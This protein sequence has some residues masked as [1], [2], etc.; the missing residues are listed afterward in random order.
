[1]SAPTFGNHALHSKVIK[2]MGKR[3]FFHLPSSSAAEKRENLTYYA[4]TGTT[5]A[6]GSVC[7]IKLPQT[8]NQYLN[9]NASRFCGRV[10]TV[11]N[12]V[13]WPNSIQSFFRRVTLL[14]PG[15]EVVQS[16]RGYN[17]LHGVISDLTVS[18][19][20]R[21]NL[22]IDSGYGSLE[23][24][25]LFAV[26]FDFSVILLNSFLNNFNLLDLEFGPFTIEIEMEKNDEALT[27]DSG[28]GRFSFTDLSFQAELLSFPPR[29]DKSVLQ[30]YA[31]GGM[32]F[33]CPAYTQY[34]LTSSSAS[35]TFNVPNNFRSA[36]TL[37]FFMRDAANLNNPLV[38]MTK[39][40]KSNL[41]NVQ[42]TIGQRRMEPMSRE[43]H[44]WNSTKR[45][46]HFQTDGIINYKTYGYR[47]GGDSSSFVLA[48]DLEKDDSDSWVSGD[49][50]RGV[51]EIKILH[52]KQPTSDLIYYAYLMRDTVVQLT[53]QGVYVT[54]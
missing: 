27:V 36:K 34:D 52:S 42:V 11:G 32:N 38:D 53:P 22:A 44:Y 41:E 10:R 4:E 39:R 25:K 30:T 29:I 20:Q 9:G 8:P 48:V 54:E 23:D 13:R 50:S 17:L 51:I 21:D 35:L 46:M 47:F 31:E 19:L 1:M 6:E 45:A 16:L 2:R 24:R 40:T 7:R 3:L 15:N 43:S 5:F 49:D 12:G 18:Q 28:V 33:H 14:G 37:L 26:E